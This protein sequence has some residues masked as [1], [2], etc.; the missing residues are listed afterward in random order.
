MEGEA[1]STRLCICCYHS[2]RSAVVVTMV[3]EMLSIVFDK[4]GLIETKLGAECEA[5][6][7]C[8]SG[9]LILG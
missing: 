2:I 4:Y 3:L 1:T 9:G 8:F 7:D 6:H 5:I